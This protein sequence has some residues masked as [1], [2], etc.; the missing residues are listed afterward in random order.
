M[1]RTADRERHVLGKAGAS[2][3]TGRR[4]GRLHPPLR[5]SLALV[6]VLSCALSG[7]HA[8]ADACSPVSAGVDT[9]H[10]NTYFGAFMGGAEGQVFNA[11]DTVL[12]AVTVWRA[13]PA[14]IV[15][16]RLY[17]LELDSTWT[18]NIQRILLYGPTL[19]I[20]GGDGVHPIQ[21]RYVLDPPL[22]LPR[23]GRY[24]FA[25][26]VAPPVC[27]GST[28]LLGDTLNSYPDGGRW[29]HP[30]SNPYFG[31]LLRGAEPTNPGDDLVFELEFC[32]P[33]PTPVR[34]TSWGDLK[35]R[36]R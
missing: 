20:L 32:G 33:P 29:Y 23:P 19:Q 6:L 27:D 31:C 18:P 1:G 28:A 14:S 9:S 35:V 3:M 10:G 13:P 17:V 7:A 21:L 16:L 4:R 8:L 34:R 24:E 26:Q 22:V 11:R 36:Y 30:R 5:G 25:I 2:Q 12:E 15:A